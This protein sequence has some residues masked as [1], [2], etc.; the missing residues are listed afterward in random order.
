[1]EPA[2]R[3]ESKTFHSGTP[4]TRLLKSPLPPA[5]PVCYDTRVNG[6]LIVGFCLALTA[7]SDP[8][9]PSE[10]QRHGVDFESW[11]RATFF[12]HYQPSSYTQKWDIPAE[13]NTRHGGIPVNP[14]AARFKTAVGLGDA[15][16]QFDI[17][18]PFLLIIGYWE[19]RGPDKHFVKVV[20]P[21]VTPQ[22][23]RR[24]W[25]PLTRADLEALDALIRD[26]SRSPQEV[27]KA[28]QAM[29]SRP[30]Y[31]ESIIVLNPKI[32]HKTQRRLQCSLRYEDV[33]QHLLPGTDPAPEAAPQLFGHPVPPILSSRPRQFT[34]PSQPSKLPP[35]PSS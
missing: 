10:V 23:W 3:K 31:S 19:Q 8:T 27:Q 6:T 14:K 35:P 33:F 11:V 9:S 1:M 17:N 13:A 30:P 20:A 16:R 28:A 25:G 5:F 24:L 15:L 29:K 7:A 2:A 12:D 21:V 4:A 26:R 32:D 22:V 34:E 18:E